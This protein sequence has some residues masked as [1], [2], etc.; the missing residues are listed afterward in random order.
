MRVRARLLDTQTSGT[1][2][3][4]R[5]QAQPAQPSRQATTRHEYNT[6][7][8]GMSFRATWHLG[9]AGTKIG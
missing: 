2:Q 7:H 1:S 4:A 6:L 5:P 3:P 8:E 9:S